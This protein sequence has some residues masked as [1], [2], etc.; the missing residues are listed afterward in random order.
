MVFPRDSKSQDMDEMPLKQDAQQLEH[1]A[2]GQTKMD[3]IVIVDVKG[4]VERPGVYEAE[5]GTRVHDVIEQAGGFTDLAYEAAVNLAQKVHDEMVILIP[6]QGDEP[7]NVTMGTSNDG[8]VRMNYA[9]QAE[10]ETIPGIGPAKAA[11]I[12]N[13]RD[14][15]GFF[16]SVE[17]LLDIPGIGEKTLENMRD[18]IQ[19]P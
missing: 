10:I 4:E 1:I 7:S 3:E 6:A 19:I 18:D 9:T 13:H 15:H 5:P 16:Q 17:D 12:I 2:I 8:K 14:E 11:A